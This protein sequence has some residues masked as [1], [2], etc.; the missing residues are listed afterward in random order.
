MVAL[1]PFPLGSRAIT[2]FKIKHANSR[3]GGGLMKY[4]SCSE[5][6][7]VAYLTNLGDVPA[8]ASAGAAADEAEQYQEQQDCVMEGKN[9]DRI[10]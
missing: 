6:D 3:S 1:K 7:K 2:C 8:Q 5:V 10:W 4:Y 9:Q